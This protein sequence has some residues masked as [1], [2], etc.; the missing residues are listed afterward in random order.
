LVSDLLFSH[1]SS[2]SSVRVLPTTRD[3]DD[4]LALSSRN[5]YLTQKARNEANI[6]YNALEVCR[7]TWN[8]GSKNGT[9]EQNRE[10]LS[11]VLKKGRGF[12][13]SE[14]KRLSEL[15]IGFEADYI[16][17]NHPTSL[18]DYEELLKSREAGQEEVDLSK[19]AILSGA[20]WIWDKQVEPIKK[21]RLID[22]F[23]LDF[24]LD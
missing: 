19:G 21:V 20:V 18:K 17:L 14:G 10:F 15:G 22:N 5:L 3:P 1:P 12:L 6:L 13:E 7:K 2:S 11:Q 23:L 8:Q 24:E 16:S 4:H 9:Q